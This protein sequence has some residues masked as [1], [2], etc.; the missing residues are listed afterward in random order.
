L[1]NNNLKNKKMVQKRK[2]L[3]YNLSVGLLLMV[4]LLWVCSKFIHFGKVAFTDNAQVKQ[5]IIPI[6]SRVQGFI[7][8]IYFEEFEYV[9]KGDTLLIIEDS[10]YRFR[11]AQ[12]MSDYQNEL[13]GKKA[14]EVTIQ[15]IQS[16]IAVTESGIEEC[17][18][19][20]DNSEKEYNRYKNLFEQKAV[21]QQLLDQVNTNYKAAKARYNQMLRQSNSTNMVKN[22]QSVRLNQNDAHIKIAEAALE[23]ARLNLNYTVVLAPFDGYTGRKNIE[24]G[25]FIQPGFTF[26]NLVNETDKWVIANYKES[27]LQNIKEGKQVQIKIDAIPGIVYKGRVKSVSRATGSSFSMIPQDN[28]SGNFVKVEQR[29]PV[30]IEFTSEN[31]PENMKKLKAG[32]NVEC[33]IKF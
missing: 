27:Q 18:I 5:Q 30:H 3:I 33:E 12:A 13:I 14:M 20:M 29:L 15:T 28:S 17:K 9:H 26:L 4:I 6:H 2:K 11:L 19:Q 25:Q 7:K 8:K 32:L 31:N 10:E 22:E 16:N 21:T 24:E 1:K 23:I